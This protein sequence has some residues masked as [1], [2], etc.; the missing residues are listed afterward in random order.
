MEDARELEARQST[1]EAA[2]IAPPSRIKNAS[3]VEPVFATDSD[4]DEG[5]FDEG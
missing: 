5:Y 3:F 2:V 1:T 4:G